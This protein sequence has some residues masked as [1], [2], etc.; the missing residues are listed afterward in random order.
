MLNEQIPGIAPAPVPPVPVS[1]GQILSVTVPPLD[2]NLL[3]LK[4]E[5]S[6]ITVNA[7]A[8]DG[9]RPAAGQRAD[10]RCWTRSTRR[11]RTWPS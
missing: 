11:R 1:D 10:R 2:L 9:R 7:R 8:D 5:T 4:L 6:P 3:G